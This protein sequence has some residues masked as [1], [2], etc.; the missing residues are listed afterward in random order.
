MTNK[1]TPA[2]ECYAV[3]ISCREIDRFDHN[4]VFIDEMKVAFAKVGLPLRPVDYRSDPRALTKALMDSN[5][6]FAICFNGF[7]SEVSV[8]GPRPGSLRSAFEAFGKPL[9]DYFHDNP[10]QETMGHQVESTTRFRHVLFTD[11]GYLAEGLDLGF[12]NVRYIPSIT[13]PTHLSKPLRP[14]RDR[15]IPLLLSV[16]LTSPD[17]ISKRHDARPTY[18]GAAYRAVYE[19]VL[20]ACVHNLRKDPRVEVRNACREAGLHFDVRTADSRFLLTS[21]V[22]MVKVKRRSLLLEK[23][24]GFPLTILSD[25]PDA[26]YDDGHN[27]VGAAKFDGVLDAMAQSRVVLCPLPHMTGFHERALGAFSAKS[28]VVSAPND[29]LETN[30]EFGSEFLQ[31][32]SIDE[33]CDILLSIEK[34]LDLGQEIANAGHERAMA[35]FSP[36]RFAATVI[37]LWRVASRS[38]CGKDDA[39][40]CFSQGE[41]ARSSRSGGHASEEASELRASAEPAGSKIGTN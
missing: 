17:W 36:G 39:I 27:R 16:G 26:A 30:F 32:E 14:L 34:N 21:T 19:A 10:S 3:V 20:E 31:Y 25:N 28:L 35:Q 38:W 7:G 8:V 37:S 2:R 41:R 29:V 40:G 9:F 15:P 6:V 23:L 11:Y 22:D 24:R 12:P 1:L 13:F 33:L 18:R 4:R 5:C